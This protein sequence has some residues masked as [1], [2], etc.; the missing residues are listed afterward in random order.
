MF[1][2]KNALKFATYILGLMAVMDI[3]RGYMHTFNIWWAS[4]YFAQMS[5]T[6][7][8]LMLMNTFGITNFLTGFIY[9]LII[10]K[11]RHLSPYILLIIP[12]SYLLG[13]L[14]A[15]MTGVL[16]LQTSAWNGQY[17][18]IIYLLS[19]LVAGSNYFIASLRESAK[20][21]EEM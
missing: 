10:L 21:R 9:L 15:R 13:I 4:D 17:M 20:K 7:D 11:A 3:V 8:T 19:S 16:Q 12:A 6:A 2:E 5:Q 18:M 14:S 1:T